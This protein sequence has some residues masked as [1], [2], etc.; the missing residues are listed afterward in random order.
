MSSEKNV[1]AIC[2]E[3]KKKCFLTY[4]DALRF[5]RSVERAN[6]KRKKIRGR[7]RNRNVSKLIQKEMQYEKRL[8]SIY[9]CKHCGY[10]H[11]SSMKTKSKK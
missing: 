5:A 1:I 3:S 7:E 9:V 8:R 6:M 10:Y 11:F 2:E 4:K